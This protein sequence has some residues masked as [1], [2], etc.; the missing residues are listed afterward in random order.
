MW[1]FSYGLYLNN[2]VGDKTYASAI[3]P[4]NDKDN[5]SDILIDKVLDTKNA[6]KISSNIESTSSSR[7]M[8]HA[9]TIK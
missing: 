1:S 9:H 4:T 5:K 8:L 6:H 3:I 7:M 2:K